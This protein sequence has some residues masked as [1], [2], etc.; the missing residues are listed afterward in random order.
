MVC[1]VSN[2]LVVEKPNFPEEEVKI[3]KYWE[4]INAFHK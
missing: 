2:Y 3:L 4:S 1:D